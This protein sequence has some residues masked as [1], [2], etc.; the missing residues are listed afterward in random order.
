MTNEEVLRHA[1][2]DSLAPEMRERLGRL[3]RLAWIQYWEGRPD[4]EQRK[5]EHPGRF[6]GWSELLEQDKEVDRQI[7][8]VLWWRG[9]LD[10]SGKGKKPDRKDKLD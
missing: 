8:T 4:Y 10:L 6:V 9:A 5:K 1:N 2:D 3:V 7:G